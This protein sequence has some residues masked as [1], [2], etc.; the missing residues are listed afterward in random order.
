M[1]SPGLRA[2]RVRLTTFDCAAALTISGMRGCT[3]V[4]LVWTRRCGIHGSGGAQPLRV[5]RKLSRREPAPEL[6]R[7]SSKG[8]SSGVANFGP[9]RRFW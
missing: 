8:L 4:N 5:E 6:G 3:L 9:N 1:S 7:S 2:A